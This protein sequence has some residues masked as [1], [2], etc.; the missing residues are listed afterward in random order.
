[1]KISVEI[2]GQQEQALA[3]AARHLTFRPMSSRSPRR[4]ILL[5]SLTPGPRVP[6]RACWRRME[7]NRELYR[8]L[9]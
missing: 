3:E 7:K 5:R 2:T 9:A 8:R 6:R 1:M 4:A